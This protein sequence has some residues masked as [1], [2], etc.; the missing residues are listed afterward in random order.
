MLEVKGMLGNDYSF[1]LTTTGRALATARNEVCQY[2]G[3]APV[4]IQQ[5]HEVV[6][7]QA[8]KIKLSRESLRQA[9]DDLVLS[10]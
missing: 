3:P 1:S 2:V 10:G 9:F 8:A 4:S 5:Y 7:A 6:K